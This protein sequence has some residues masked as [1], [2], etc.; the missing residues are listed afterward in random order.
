[1]CAFS[2]LDFNFKSNSIAIFIYI[3]KNLT[4]FPVQNLL[5]L[6]FWN[7]GIFPRYM[8]FFS[9]ICIA[10]CLTSGNFCLIF[11]NHYNKIPRKIAGKIAGKIT[12]KIAKKIVGKLTGIC[13]KNY[14]EN[15][16]KN[17]RKKAE[18]FQEKLQEKLQ[19]FL[20]N[21]LKSLQQNF[22]KNCRKNC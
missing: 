5:E 4:H 10:K 14:R 17:F 6:D 1:M 13:G 22:M 16:V 15:F 2:M 19:Q 9:K 8:Q 3:Y 12:R 20:L 21:F 11:L 7:S 18:R